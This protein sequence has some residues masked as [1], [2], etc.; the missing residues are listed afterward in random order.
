MREK[1]GHP[2]RLAL[3]WWLGIAVLALLLAPFVPND[4]LPSTLLWC[5]LYSA[6]LSF[7]VIGLLLTKHGHKLLIATHVVA[8]VSC[9]LMQWL[10][11]SEKILDAPLGLILYGLWALIGVLVC[12]SAWGWLSVVVWNSERGEGR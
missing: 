5:I 7:G 11:W 6:A 1:I 2:V 12:V 8:I 10:L 4:D 9:A 3:F